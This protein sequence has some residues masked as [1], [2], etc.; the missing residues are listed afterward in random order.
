MSSFSDLQLNVE[1][2][3]FK[4]NSA[5]DHSR[6]MDGAYDK[7][8]W[9]KDKENELSLKTTWLCLIRGKLDDLEGWLYLQLYNLFSLHNFCEL[10][11]IVNSFKK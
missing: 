6:N 8:T 4:I 3:Y 10:F 5:I 2:K 1:G 9:S 11:T 7:G